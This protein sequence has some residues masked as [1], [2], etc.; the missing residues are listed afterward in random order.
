MHLPPTYSN[1]KIKL[2][3]FT[4]TDVYTLHG[5]Y[6]FP[7]GT[8][9]QLSVDDGVWRMVFGAAHQIYTN[10]YRMPGKSNS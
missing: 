10:A 9:L 3:Y 7:I 1:E 6:V 8:R 5:F 4:E 2:S